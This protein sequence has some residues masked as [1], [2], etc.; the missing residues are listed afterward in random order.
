MKVLISGGGTGGHI[1]PAIAIAKALQRL[2]PD[3]EILFVGAK[4]KMEM[5]KVPSAGFPIKG[6]WISGFNRSLSASNLIFPIKLMVSSIDAYQILRKFHPDIV[7]GVGGFAS[8][9]VMRIASYLKIPIV[10]QEQNSFPG[11]TNRILAKKASRIFTAYPDMEEFFPA[12]KTLL[13]GNPVR[14]EVIKIEGKREEGLSYLELQDN[15]TTIM[16]IGG[17]QGALSINEAVK[18]CF[19]INNT[20]WIWQTGKYY[21]ETAKLFVS[22]NQLKNVRVRDFIDRIDLA[23][24]AADVIISRAG[25][26]AISELCVVG[27]PS[28]LVPYPYA[29]ANHQMHNARRLEAA[30]AAILI[31]DNELQNSLFTTLQQLIMDKDWQK[32]LSTNISKWGIPDADERIAH[33]II[34]M[35]ENSKPATP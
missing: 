34:Q 25:A 11:V 5:D 24:A 30:R 2:R 26:I 17:S 6:L 27:K 14:R 15:L 1:F 33:E 13:T 32:S 29:A 4:G 35:V 16:V 31:K 18:N 23:Y 8:G 20:Q 19:L 10:I 7:V 12:E 28:I 3:V 22:K 21:Y 9:P